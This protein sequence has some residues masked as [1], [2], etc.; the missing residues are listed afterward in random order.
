MH[1]ANLV[2]VAARR[3]ALNH[4]TSVGIRYGSEGVCL[5]DA[6]GSRHVFAVGSTIRLTRLDVT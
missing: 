3:K 6:E 1:G 4:E 5:G 2:A